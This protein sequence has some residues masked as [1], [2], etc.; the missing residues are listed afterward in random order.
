[1]KIKIL[2]IAFICIC[3]SATAQVTQRNLLMNKYSLADIQQSIV[4]IE[5]FKPFPAT[6]QEWKE[7]V[8]DSILQSFIAEGVASLKFKF[9][10]VSFKS[11][12]AFKKRGNRS[13]YE[14]ET[15]AKRKALVYLVLAESMEGKGRFMD[16]IMEGLWSVC[17]E[18][19]W[20]VPAHILKTEGIPDVET[21]NA[22]LFTAETATTLGLVNYF[23]GNKLDEVS[24]LLRKRLILEI[25]NRFFKPVLENINK[26]TGYVRDDIKVNNW[27]PW[28]MSNYIATNLL[29]E[30]DNGKRSEYLYK[31]L[32]GLDRYLNGLGDDGGCDEGVNYWF[33]AGGSA[34]DCL[35]LAQIGTNGK[36][37]IFDAPL[38]RNMTSYI[39]KMHIG[40]EYFMNIGDGHTAMNG[41][42]GIFLYRLGT[43]IKDEQ[44]QQFGIWAYTNI[45]KKVTIG[46]GQKYR[47]IQDLLT[48]RKI[49]TS[50]AQYKDPEHVWVDDIQTMA[51]RT[52]GNLYLGTHAGDNGKSHNHNDVGDFIVYLNN[53]PF[54]VDAGSGTYTAR[55]FN[56]HRYELWTVQSQYHN[57][58]TINGFGQHDGKTFTSTNVVNTNNKE[59]DKLTMDIAGT[60]PKEAGIISW[61]RTNSLVKDK[62][63]IQITDEYILDKKPISIQQT[64]MTNT[65]VDVS[66]KGEVVFKGENDKL[67][68]EYD[69]ALFTVSTETPP[70][71]E[72]EYAPF[73]KEA[74]LIKRV[75]FTA[76]DPKA[77]GRFVYV[78]KKG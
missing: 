76:K 57:L 26:K 67:V 17:E 77:K 78:F 22:D 27:N 50:A 7:Q 23:V 46:L 59:E 69:A 37:N 16:A 11:I 10:S 68:L 75:L 74:K 18:S 36:V 21:P 13:D 4:S 30:K 45:N 3:L 1:M 8:P 61:K 65:I 47:S 52:K 56:K 14:S 48:I 5:K 73:K 29:I 58:P 41:L 32:Q 6:P 51:A 55:T 33:A 64:F 39:Y 12:L 43:T 63:I 54:I 49:L 42:N 72:P 28:I 35:E 53:Q 70:L 31:A 60:Y 9:N 62:E 34:F 66:K 20:G 25:N 40:E 38:V 44:M 2:I 19:Y 24:P 15:F 71:D